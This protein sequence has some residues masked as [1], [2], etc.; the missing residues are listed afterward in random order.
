[1]H[2]AA[3]SGELSSVVY[4]CTRDACM[5]E[6]KDN[7]L[8]TPLMNTINSN[9]EASFIYL[10][11]KEGCDLRNVDVNGHTLLH[12]A[13]RSNALNIAKLLMHISEANSKPPQSQSE[14]NSNGFGSPEKSTT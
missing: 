11:F 7:A 8:M 9:H 5:K 2:V 12:L 10:H 13:S 14:L 4:M 1:M 6:A 3:V